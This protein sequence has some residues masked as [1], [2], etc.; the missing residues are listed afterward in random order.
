MPTTINTVYRGI[1]VLVAVRG[2]SRRNL[3][4][5]MI[6]LKR[7]L[8]EG[9][10]DGVCG[11]PDSQLSSPTGRW[12]KDK[13]L[14]LT[15][16][17]YNLPTT[18]FPFLTNKDLIRQDRYIRMKSTCDSTKNPAWLKPLTECQYSLL[19][20]CAL[21]TDHLPSVYDASLSTIVPPWQ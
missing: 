18:S 9:W 19:R 2:R 6:S 11:E 15:I 13:A 12:V 7:R 14:I 5:A 1:I 10:S 8:I 20:T 3:I 17:G 16:F 21:G 4:Q